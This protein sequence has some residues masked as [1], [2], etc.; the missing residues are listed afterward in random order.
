MGKGIQRID[1]ST[2]GVPCFLQINDLK[3]TPW[4]SKKEVRLSAKQG[5]SLLLDNYP[6]SV[7]KHIIINAPFW[8][9]AFTTVLSRFLTTRTKSKFVHARPSKV[10]ETLLK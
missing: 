10:T 8:Y 7:T 5:V 9:Y 2:I 4:P 3:N 6:E 1:L